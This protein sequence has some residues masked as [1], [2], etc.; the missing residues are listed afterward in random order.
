MT[1]FSVFDVPAFWTIHLCYWIILLYLMMKRQILYIIKYKYVQF[2]TGKQVTTGLKIRRQQK[3]SKHATVHPAIDLLH[4]ALIVNRK[5]RFGYLTWACES[6]I[7]LDRDTLHTRFGSSHECHSG[8]GRCA[9]R[10]GVVRAGWTCSPRLLSVESL[11]F[12]LLYLL[13]QIVARALRAR[14]LPDELPS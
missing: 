1:F 7:E 3:F 6:R 12:R 13:R 10:V 5:V 8:D 11:R 4:C 9:F 2:N 14:A